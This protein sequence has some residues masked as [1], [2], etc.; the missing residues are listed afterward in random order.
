MLRAMRSRVTDLTR[1][2]QD[3][4]DPDER[5]R[6]H[7]VVGDAAGD[8]FRVQ[9]HPLRVARVTRRANAAAIPASARACT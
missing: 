7:V 9:R 6:L 4:G 1:P 8:A 2:G 3:C 5:P